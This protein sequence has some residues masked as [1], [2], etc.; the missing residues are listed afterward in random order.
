[1]NIVTSETQLADPE[2]TP[3]YYVRVSFGQLCE[4]SF[5][6]GSVLI[7][8]AGSELNRQMLFDGGW[9]VLNKNHSTQ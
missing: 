4:I 9:H 8:R 6:Y 3:E 1:M 5:A 2:G 7:V